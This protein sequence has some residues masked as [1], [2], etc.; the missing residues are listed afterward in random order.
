MAEAVAEDGWIVF[1]VIDQGR[2]IPEDKIAGVFER[3]KQA[4][5]SD[6]RKGTGLGLPICKMLVENHGGEIGA[7]S[8]VGVGTTFYARIPESAG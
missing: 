8:K 7:I 1:R 5:S 6:A 3:F 4:E 2:G